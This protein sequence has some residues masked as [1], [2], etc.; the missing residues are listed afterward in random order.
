[1]SFGAPAEVATLE[2]E[3]VVASGDRAAT[4]PEAVDPL[5]VRV[6][7]DADAAVFVDGA[8]GDDAAVGAMDA[9]L[10]SIGAAAAVADGRDIYVRSTT[11]YVEAAT[12]RLGP[13]TSLYGGFDVEWKRD[14][15]QRVRLQGAAVA[16]VIDGD[17]DRT[18]GSIELTAADAAPGRRSIAIRIVDAETVTVADSRILAGAGGSGTGDTEAGVSAGVV[19]VGTGELPRRAFDGHRLRRGERSERTVP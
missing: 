18:V 12:V 19:A 11:A 13:G 2:F 10:R 5:V 16:I 9:P 3:L 15:S 6:F 1:M 7:E 17:D 8:R 4:A 14:R